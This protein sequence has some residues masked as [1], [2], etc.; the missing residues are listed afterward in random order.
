MT[1][2][3]LLVVLLALAATSVGLLAV[4]EWRHNIRQ[5]AGRTAQAVIAEMGKHSASNAEECTEPTFAEARE[6][7]PV[8]DEPA[9]RPRPVPVGQILER[10]EGAGYAIR[11]NWRRDD[12]QRARH[13]TGGT[14]PGDFPTAVLPV[15][16]PDDA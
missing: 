7:L 2:A 6:L 3:V 16:S 12:E 15:V 11:L 13:G 5:A 4:T 1:G 8:G 9:K 14:D 10:V